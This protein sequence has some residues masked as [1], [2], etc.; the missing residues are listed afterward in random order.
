MGETPSPA[1]A[2]SGGK[3]YGTLYFGGDAGQGSVFAF[4]PATN[5]LT[6]LHSFGGTGDGMGPQTNV[7]AHA[8]TLY[9]TT[10]EGGAARALSGALF[11]IDTATGAETILHSFNSQKNDGAGPNGLIWH[12]GALYGNTEQGGQTNSG[13]VFRLDPATGHDK[14]LYQFG[15]GTDGQAPESSLLYTGGLF[16]GTTAFGGATGNGT[17]FSVDPKTGAETLLY[18][19]TGGQDGAYPLGG[20]VALNGQLYG[21]AAAGGTGSCS[22]FNTHGCGTVFAFDP[23]TGKHQSLYTFSGGADGDTPYAG[24]AVQGKRLFGTTLTGGGTGCNGQGC[25][26]LFS[27]LP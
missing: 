21:T 4:D 2:E 27:L 16:Y 15:A 10:F 20:L 24:L 22:L 11:A 1:L 13:T 3:L 25:G 7:I 14:R 23:A 6:T 17:L 19:F 5:A 18:S 12:E 9:G 26:T 8:G